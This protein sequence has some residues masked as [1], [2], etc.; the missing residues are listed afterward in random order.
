MYQ[1]NLILGDCNNNGKVTFTDLL[2][3]KKYVIGINLGNTINLYNADINYD[4]EINILD[5][6]CLKQILINLNDN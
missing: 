6:I 4:T 3:L 5:I 1:E 2:M